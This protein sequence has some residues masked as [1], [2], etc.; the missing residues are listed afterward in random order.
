[1]GAG[2]SV[3]SLGNGTGGAIDVGVGVN[4]AGAGGPVYITNFHT[5]GPSNWNPS[6]E[7]VKV[8]GTPGKRDL[9][10]CSAAFVPFPE[11]DER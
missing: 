6:G 1:M 2:V 3:L 8:T 9:P 10:S 4:V 7:N 11:A 5:L